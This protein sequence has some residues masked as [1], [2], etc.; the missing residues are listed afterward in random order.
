MK[1]A[2]IAGGILLLAATAL[3]AVPTAAADPVTDD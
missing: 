2:R 3:V 1:T